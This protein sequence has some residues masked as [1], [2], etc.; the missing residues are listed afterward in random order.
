M[1]SF[2]FSKSI[3][4]QRHVIVVVEVVETYYGAFVQLMEETLDEVGTDEAGRAG[5]EDG[6][7]NNVE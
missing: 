5:N 2:K 7:H 6:F 4:L 3:L 1:E